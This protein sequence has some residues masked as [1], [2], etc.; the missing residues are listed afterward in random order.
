MQDAWTPERRRG[1]RRPVPFPLYANTHD[2]AWRVLVRE[3]G[4]GGMVIECERPLTAGES[5][6]FTIGAEGGDVGPIAGHVAHSRL[7][8][9]H[10]S[11]A[12]P[13]CLTGVVFAR[14]PA[15]T[16]ARLAALL[17]TIDMRTAASGRHEAP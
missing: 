17:E 3:L 6:L 1:D 11:D 7:L 13:P 2:G 16:A 9:N 15:G 8:I 5:L 4:A 10:D 12:R 14:V